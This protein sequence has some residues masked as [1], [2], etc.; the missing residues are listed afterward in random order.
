ML[1]IKMYKKLMRARRRRRYAEV[2]W[3]FFKKH[4]RRQPSAAAGSRG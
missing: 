4:P 1:Y 2:V 3:E